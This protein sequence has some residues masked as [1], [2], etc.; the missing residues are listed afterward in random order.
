MKKVF[1]FFVLVSCVLSCNTDDDSIDCALFDPAFP[2]LI[3]KFVDENGDNLIENGTILPDDISATG[4][5]TGAGFRFIPPSMAIQ[6]QPFDNT[7]SLSIASM[8]SFQH[9]I[10]LK[11]QQPISID[12]GAEKVNIQ[13][14]ISYYIPVNANS[15][16]ND[17]N[18]DQSNNSLDFLVEISL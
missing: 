15:N 10:R 11:D 8:E 9:T 16:G 6:P 13:C 4:N 7:I 14:N 17:L 12:F 1:T 18:I 3:L 2:S 5:F